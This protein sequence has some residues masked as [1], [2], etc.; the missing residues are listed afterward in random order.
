MEEAYRE[1]KEK[2]LQIKDKNPIDILLQ[3]MALPHIPIHGP[4]HHVLDGASLL[5]ALYNNGY[6]INLEEA[7]D[8]MIERGKEIPGAICG[9]W[10]ICGSSASLGAA[11]SIIHKTGPLS[12]NDYYKDNLHYT[13][14]ALKTIG[15]IG[16]PRCCKRN[17]Y[18]SMQTMITFLNEHYHM[19]IE[20][21][22]IECAYSEKNKQC[23][24]SRCPFYKKES[25]L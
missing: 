18:L 3:L 11:L 17:A 21:K 7:L 8:E 10:G 13:S 4:Q 14:L 6:D 15:D 19:N 23:I 16:G 22:K 24:K 25:S 2:C 1:I 12:D 5:T 9:E 20:N